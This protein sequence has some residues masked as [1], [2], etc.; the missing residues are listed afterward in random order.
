MPQNPNATAK[1]LAQGIWLKAWR[2][3]QPLVLPCESPSQAHRLAFTLYNAVREVRKADREDPGVPKEL[4][5]AV[6]GIT[7]QRRDS[8]VTLAK[9][10]ETGI[11]KLMAQALGELAVEELPTLEELAADEAAKRLERNLAE[12]KTDSAVTPY[13]TREVRRG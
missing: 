4:W 13:Y 10:A 12:G 1:K 6:Q 11:G 9:V 8:S 7:I 2:E 5:D 3:E